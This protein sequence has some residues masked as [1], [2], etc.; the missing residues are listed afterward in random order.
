M[1]PYAMCKQ[2]QS[3][4]PRTSSQSVQ[5]LCCQLKNKEKTLDTKSKQMKRGDLHQALD[6]QADLGL[7]CP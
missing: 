6:A 2:R 7:R 4:Q 5:D 1:G 3:D